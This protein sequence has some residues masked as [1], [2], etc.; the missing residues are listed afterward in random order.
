MWGMDANNGRPG[1]CRRGT[2]GRKAPVERR[3]ERD[4]R[5]RSTFVTKFKFGHK[6]NG[7]AEKRGGG[8]RGGADRPPVMHRGSRGKLRRPW[9]LFL[10]SI[11]WLL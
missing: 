9:P 5:R 6:S 10:V 2:A 3:G 7:L 1:A 11:C 4:E 8:E